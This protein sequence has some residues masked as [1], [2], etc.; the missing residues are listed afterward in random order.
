MY[1]ND[2]FSPAILHQINILQTPKTVPPTRNQVIKYMNLWEIFFFQ[3]ITFSEN[4][5]II[6]LCNTVTTYWEL[7]VE[8]K[9]MLHNAEG[10]SPFCAKTQ[11]ITDKQMDIYSP[12]HYA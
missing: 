10:S 8:W 11:D 3:I 7:N 4:Y 12:A 5:I 9:K 6:S 1:W 2:L